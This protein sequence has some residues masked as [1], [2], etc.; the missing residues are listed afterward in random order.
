[1]ATEQKLVSAGSLDKL[2]KLLAAEN[3]MVEH[4]PIKTAYFDVKNRVLALP[5]WKEMT[6]TL[7][8]M[9]VLHEVGHAL[10]TPSDGWKGAIDKVKDEDSAYVAQT[11]KGYLNVVEDARIERR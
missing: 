5:M 11:F 7:Y 9:L 2:A 4:R 8:H 3:I 10:D 1:M 6:E